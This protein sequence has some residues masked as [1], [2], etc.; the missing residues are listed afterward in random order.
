MELCPKLARLI[1]AASLV[2]VAAQAEEQDSPA[3]SVAPEQ[4]ASIA[5][6]TTGGRVLDVRPLSTETP[7]AYEVRLLINPGRVRT[8]VVEGDSGRLR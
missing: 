7:L 1:L 8:V 5:R 6:D 4:A 3:A 2:T